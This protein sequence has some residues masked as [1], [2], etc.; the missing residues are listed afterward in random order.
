MVG[1][2]DAAQE[3]N[4]RQASALEELRLFRTTLD[5]LKAR[6]PALEYFVANSS[7][8]EEDDDAELERIVRSFGD[9]V[10]TIAGGSSDGDVAGEADGATE[11]LPKRARTSLGH[12]ASIK[13]A[14]A[15]GKGKQKQDPDE[16][17]AGVEASVNL[18]FYALG[19]PR[20]WAEPNM[21]T[22]GLA[23]DDSDV[24]ATPGPSTSPSYRHA[25]LPT[26][27]EGQADSPV[28]LFANGDALLRAAPTPEQER[29]I[30]HQGLDV[31]GFHVRLH[32]I[33]AAG[34]RQTRLKSRI[35]ARR[36]LRS[37]LLRAGQRVPRP[38]QQPLRSGVS[39]M[40]KRILCAA[41]CQ[42]EARHSRATRGDRLEQFR[43]ERMRKPMV[44]AL[45]V[46]GRSDP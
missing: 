22:S 39:G 42:R 25:I 33:T 20:V 14:P 40:V 5:S 43:H 4:Q 28:A 8:K 2:V 34:L 36:H 16:G 45:L 37:R 1:S 41:C 7:L 15:K 44:R 19:R 11:P 35:A 30:F 17:E 13:G 12:G 29:I 10:T 31:Y 18:E 21:R 24:G 6:L 27:P 9:P 23:I 38:G 46:P 26:A 3:L 32:M